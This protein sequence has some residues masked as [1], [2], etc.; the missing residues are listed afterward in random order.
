[1]ALEKYLIYL[2]KSRQDNENET[3]EEVLARHEK[4]LQEYAIKEFGGKIDEKNIYR[5]I[6]SGETIDDR[7]QINLLFERMQNEDIEGVLVIETSR[8]T[9]GDL[10][11]C[12][13][14]VHLFKYTNTL[15]IT[16][17]KTYNLDDKF[18]RKFFEM[19]LTKGNDYL[20][21][22]KEIL[23]RGRSAS[24]HEGNYIGG[25]APYGYDR[26]R[27]GKSPTLKINEKEAQ[28]VRLIFDMYLNDGIGYY[29]IANSINALGFRSKKNTLFIG[30]VVNDILHNPIY[31]G[32]IK[33]QHRKEVK[34]YEDGKLVKKRI[35][36]DNCELIDG[37]HEPIISIE[38]FQAVQERKG[39]NI[40]LS[41]NKELT[42]IYSGILKCGIC[43]HSIGRK[44][45]KKPTNDRYFCRNRQ[46][47][48]ISER[49]DVLDKAIIEALKE[50]LHDFEAQINEDNYKIVEN[51]NAI[52][53]Q[54]EKDLIKIEQKQ[55]QL[56]DFLEN[57]IYSKE[58]FI[59][60]NKSLD[61][62]R[63]RTKNAIK[64]A[65][66]TIPTLEDYKEKT[67]TLHQAIDMLQDENISALTKNNFLKGFIKV[68]Y[69]TKETKGNKWD[70]ENNNFK[71]TIKLF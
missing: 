22:T 40:R 57:G 45:D 44:S 10:L 43:G 48:N 18:D 50:T 46:C 26:I 30:K 42:N 64:E 2:R 1:M 67:L 39:K 62:E 61:E 24:A 13:R 5:E 23:A 31:I 17:Q 15:I 12:G 49:T 51:H 37:K 36:N 69:F 11:D 41:P 16:P 63:Q 27:I 68:I 32:K 56:Y 6:V 52:I 25:T 58:V 19:E 33:Y 4:Q 7:P 59:N 70:S 29:E 8:L 34:V 38:Q 21:Y 54:L 60:R 53:S 3:I 66:D 20:E 9:R 28:A 14:V 65:K 55:E 47:E 35:K 71:L